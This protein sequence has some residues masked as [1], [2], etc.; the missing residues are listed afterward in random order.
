MKPTKL[1][2]LLSLALMTLPAKAQYPDQFYTD[3]EKI[4]GWKRE[5]DR[6][7]TM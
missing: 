3:G 4:D 1:V 5:G 7:T 2:P 6:K